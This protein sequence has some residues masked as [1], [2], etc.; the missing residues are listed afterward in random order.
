MTD[1]QIPRTNSQ[2]F[3]DKL[4][5][6]R[7]LA[8]LGRFPRWEAR[9]FYDFGNNPDSEWIVAS[10]NDHRHARRGRQF[11]E[12][13][14]KPRVL[15]YEVVRSVGGKGTEALTFSAAKDTSSN[16]SRPVNSF[17]NAS[18]LHCWSVSD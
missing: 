5:Q 1:K 16:N 18:R 3:L 12:S 9:Y 7:E 14:C 4:G 6:V 15:T 11:V 8:R 17:G 13:G 10:I 2:T